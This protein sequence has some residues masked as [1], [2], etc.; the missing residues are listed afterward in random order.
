MHLKLKLN[1]KLKLFIMLLTERIAGH[2]I[3]IRR[4]SMFV[5]IN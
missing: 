1:S 3:S 4:I 2:H 5:M